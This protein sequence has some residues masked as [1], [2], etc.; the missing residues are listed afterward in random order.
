MKFNSLEVSNFG[1]VKSGTI[2]SE[3]IMVFFG[4]NNTGKSMVARLVRAASLFGTGSP[5]GLYAEMFKY[6]DA[7]PEEV[8]AW[9]MLYHGG[10][11]H[12]RA[13]T[14]GKKECTITM[15]GKKKTFS[16]R[17]TPH[18]NIGGGFYV[19]KSSLPSMPTEKSIYIPASR[20]GTIE[21]FH[22]ITQMKNQL[23]HGMFLAVSAA[24][25]SKAADMRGFMDSTENL[26]VFM[27]EFYDM[28]LDALTNGVDPG[29]LGAFHS[30]FGG[31]IKQGNDITR[32]L[33]FQDEYGMSMNLPDAGSGVVS[34][35]S[36][37]L[38]LHHV[39]KGGS[40]IVEEPGACLDPLQMFKLLDVLGA[41]AKSRKISLVLTTHDDNVMKKL[42]SMVS[43]KILKPS[44][45]GLYYF[46]RDG[47][48]LTTI[49][50][51]PVDNDGSAEQPIF[52]QAMDMLI[53]EFSK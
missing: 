38:G 36:I 17:F 13:V 47:D 46:D 52:Q 3:K 10:L 48:G 8:M 32:M 21:L 6:V 24:S 37:L 41:A 18:D 49:Q 4:A 28:F 26:P 2:G 7:T 27:N 20:T 45:I 40:L 50:K 19:Y 16:S 22:S 43:R 1:P 9:H 25:G 30:V 44:D 12:G 11:T 31:R 35:L 33:E 34:A 42:L 14:H 23:L 51:M 39:M 53:E 29:T 15:K 5:R